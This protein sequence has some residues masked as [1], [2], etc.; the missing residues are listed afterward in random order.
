MVLGA[1]LLYK[2]HKRRGLIAMD[3]G[4]EAS[5]KKNDLEEPSDEGEKLLSEEFQSPQYKG[6]VG[7]DI[8][9]IP[10]SYKDSYLLSAE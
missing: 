9:H 3:L 2:V 6:G 1:L 7:A 10:L 8:L 5:N 4:N